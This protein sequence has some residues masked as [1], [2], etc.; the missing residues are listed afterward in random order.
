VTNLVIWG[1]G[2]HAKVVLDIARAVGTA[3]RIVFVDDDAAK[4]GSSISD[5]QIL[6]GPEALDSFRG[7]AIVIAVGQNRSRARCFGI[8]R[9]KGLRPITLVHPTAIVSPSATLGI[10]S[11]VMPGAI[12]NAGAVVGDNCIVNTGAVVEHD[13]RIGDHVHVSPRAVL[14]GAVTVGAYA[15]VG[16]G[17]VVLPGAN[18]GSDSLVGAGA[19]VL[20]EVPAR[21]TVV[22]VPARVMSYA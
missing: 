13:C 16:M 5:C 21:C 11:V 8:A 10:G 14:G 9:A 20:K 1:T 17:A 2:G 7:Q 4:A 12:V 6:G 22:G 3:G 15:H 18:I 19:V